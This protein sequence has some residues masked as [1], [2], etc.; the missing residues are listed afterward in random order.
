MCKQ[1]VVPIWSC[2]HSTNKKITNPYN[3]TSLID[4][5]CVACDLSLEGTGMSEMSCK[6]RGFLS[7][8][9]KAIV[10]TIVYEREGSSKNPMWSNLSPPPPHLLTWNWFFFFKDWSSSPLWKKKL[11]LLPWIAY[12]VR[13]DM[14]LSSWDFFF[15]T[16][17][18]RKLKLLLDTSVKNTT[19]KL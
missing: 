16:C 15:M 3:I 2:R 19:Q 10:I 6:M 13:I 8:T 11:I 9:I 4:H 18:K 1:V 17:S 7:K 12:L 14:T 5:D